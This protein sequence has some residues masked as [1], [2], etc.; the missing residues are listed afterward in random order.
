MCL[1]FYKCIYMCVCGC[2]SMCEHVGVRGHTIDVALVAPGTFLFESE[3]LIDLDV[4]KEL[5]WLSRKLQ[6]STLL[7]LPKATVTGLTF[8]RLGSGDETQV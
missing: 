3:S 6:G 8:F 1:G 2:S 5:G 7:C 4:S